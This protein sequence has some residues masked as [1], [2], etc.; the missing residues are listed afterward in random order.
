VRREG[1]FDQSAIDAQI[2]DHFE[3][4][5]ENGFPLWNLMMLELWR[6]EFKV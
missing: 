2:E 5:A 1:Y 6:R 4:R 3:R